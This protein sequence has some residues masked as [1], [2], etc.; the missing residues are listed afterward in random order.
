MMVKLSLLFLLLWTILDLW[1]SVAVNFQSRVRC[2][3]I[4]LL[5]KKKHF[6]RFSPLFYKLQVHVCAWFKLKCATALCMIPSF[7]CGFT[8]SINLC[9]LQSEWFNWNVLLSTRSYFIIKVSTLWS[10]GN[11]ITCLIVCMTVFIST[12]QMPP[13]YHQSLKNLTLHNPHPHLP[14]KVFNHALQT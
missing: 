4:G 8:N 13:S 3:V 9:C 11:H 7:C 2:F 14:N 5:K 6:K 12:V 10:T 1:V